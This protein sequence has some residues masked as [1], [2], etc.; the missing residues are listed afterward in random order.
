MG[1]ITQARTNIAR[2]L[3]QQMQNG[4][5]PMNQGQP[6]A[7]LQSMVSNP[8]QVQM[9]Q[10][11]GNGQ[12]ARP[13]QPP[14]NGMPNQ[15]QMM[16][17]ADPQARMQ[18]M[19]P[20][21]PHTVVPPGYLTQRDGDD[22]ARLA[23][24]MAQS[25]PADQLNN[26]RVQLENNPHR[27]QLLAQGIDPLTQWFKQQATRRI[28]EM[29]RLQNNQLFQ[30]A[31]GFN[32]EQP[33]PISQNTAHTQGPQATAMSTSQSFDPA[34]MG[35]VDQ[36]IAQQQNAQ[37]LA[38]AGHAVV[39]A[40]NVQAMSE[41]QRNA[42]RATPQQPN[43]QGPTRPSQTPNVPQQSQPFWNGQG[44]QQTGQPAGQQ[45]DSFQNGAT[46]LPAHLQG[47]NGGLNAPVGRVQQQNTT[48]PTLTRGVGP[49][50]QTT[51]PQNMW[52]QQGAPQMPNTAQGAPQSTLPNISNGAPQRPRPPP[53]KMNRQ[54]MQNY[55]NSLPENDRRK[56]WMQMQQQRA[57]ASGQPQTGRPES[58]VMQAQRSQVG[59][60]PTTQVPGHAINGNQQ[61]NGVQQHQP[62]LQQPAQPQR[63]PQQPGDTARMA[64]QRQQAALASG[65]L[66]PDVERMMDQHLYPGGIL[67]ANNALSKLP[68][69]VKTWG[70]LKDWVKKNV[71]S[72]PPGSEV[73]LRGLQGLHYQ[74]ISSKQPNYQQQ[75]GMQPTAPMMPSQNQPTATAPAQMPNI[76]PPTAQDI[77][78]ARSKHL[79]LQVATDDQ[80]RMVLIKQRQ[81]VLMRARQT[82]LNPQQQAQM[83]YVQQ[84]RQQQL[85]QQQ[86]QSV[87]PGAQPNQ[88]PQAP[89]VPQKQQPQQSKQ[90]QAKDQ[91]QGKA[92]QAPMQPTNKGV[93]RGSSDDVVE[94]PDPKIV[95][96]QQ[97][98]QATKTS[99]KGSAPNTR[100]EQAVQTTQ[101]SK[102][103]Q[104]A[105]PRAKQGQ[106]SQTQLGN[107][108]TNGA[109]PQQKSMDS[110]QLDAKLKKLVDEVARSTPPRP[111]VP[112][113]AATRARMIPKLASAQAM[114]VRMDSALPVFHRMF[115]GEDNTRE[116]IRTVGDAL[117]CPIRP[118]TD[119]L[120]RFLLKAQYKDADTPIDNFTISS[121]ELEK[122]CNMLHRSF[123]HIMHRI[124]QEKAEKAKAK[125]DTPHNSQ[126]W[127]P[128]QQPAKQQPPVLSAANLQ[129]HQ[130]NM[131]AERQASVQKS[132]NNSN[133]A[134]PAPTS[135]KPP[136]TPWIGAQSPHGVPVYGPNE[137]TQDNLKLPTSKKRKTNN[138]PASSAST[139]AQQAST[140]LQKPSP[141]GNKIPS[142]EVQRLHAPTIHKCTDP[143]CSSGTVGFA[144]QS[145]LEKHM[146]DMH[147]PKEPVIE[148]PLQ[149][150]LEQIRFA[151]NLDGNGEP[152]SKVDD[153]AVQTNMGSSAM[154]KS[155]SMQ[156][157]PAMKQET[158]T[159][160]SRVPTHT[161][162]SPASHLLKTPQATNSIKTPVSETKSL[163]KDA[164]SKDTT[165]TPLITTA[166]DPWAF[167][168]ISPSTIHHAFSGL[169]T[170][171]G[172][173][174]WSK[175]QDYHLTP[176]SMSSSDPTSPSP[177]P[178][179][180]SENDLVK[181]NMDIVDDR[182]WIPINWSSDPMMTT[183]LEELNLGEGRIGRL[184]RI[185]WIGR[186]C[187][188]RRG[189]RRKKGLGWR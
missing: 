20:N 35:N 156:G 178:S 100:P 43:Q 141:L 76:A 184:G 132:S 165:N 16:A 48:M 181:I 57:V 189:R 151:L 18:A 37:R 99:Q 23:S 89:M 116:L 10:R 135:D 114:L 139:P 70:Q 140:P 68:Q 162:P 104:A 145:E 147:E 53:G 153:A 58:V 164:V 61:A 86:S 126:E 24:Q 39:P 144:T 122:S 170:L 4:Q 8:N 96:Q 98:S 94:V 62:P 131:Q 41:Q 152:K 109:Q 38:E 155:A 158:A 113:D 64:Q 182:S 73:K 108:A 33:R 54:Q 45:Q 110:N 27:Q 74:S 67:N 30:G 103:G 56:F 42:M 111:P 93:K 51:Q 71:G 172:P 136:H 120:Q 130:N 160:M 127:L 105:E 63:P 31:N 69:T 187:L 47:Q 80:V 14:A 95:E 146:V 163:P 128:N 19:P 78:M 11:F 83:Q 29:K 174:A 12:I 49:Q 166:D 159:P 112:M 81:G 44:P 101:K 90:G 34:F 161:G 85:Q 87:P 82:G 28:L 66:T 138:Q 25:T 124:A 129:Q 22:I 77:Q 175:F 97:R 7:Q 52:P 134:P 115:G 143:S 88:A 32:P 72:L 84:H 26:I 59:P 3:Q 55:V 154:R 79:R 119:F 21:M 168:L 92:P 40:S 148:D 125:G 65:S 121:D 169:S 106:S 13:N 60:Q 171:N 46:S 180:I 6:Q 15:Q 123:T 91:P 1:E 176:E 36:I 75:H 173:K 118:T 50:S 183:E 142:P 167:S 137:L 107:Q 157:T 186:R 2:N 17:M 185:R 149:F 5:P 188:G 150:S 9:Q 102:G 177:R 179:D 117:F 133:R